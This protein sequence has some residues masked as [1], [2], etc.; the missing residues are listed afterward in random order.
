MRHDGAQYELKLCLGAD[1]HERTPSIVVSG[2]V[3]RGS[4]DAFGQPLRHYSNNILPTYPKNTI[5][6]EHVES[7]KLS[8]IRFRHRTVLQD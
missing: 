4:L 1:E 5:L 7:L 8:L 6:T 3:W 2:F